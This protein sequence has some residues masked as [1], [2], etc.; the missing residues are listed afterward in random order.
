MLSTAF[1]ISGLLALSAILNTYLPSACKKADFSVI[2]GPF[3][4]PKDVLTDAPAFSFF[5]S[6]LANG[7]LAAA[8]GLA[9]SDLSF[10]LIVSKI[11]ICARFACL[12]QNLKIK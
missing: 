6:F 2:C 3:S 7:F 5:G 1:L 11:V 9:S 10:F 8:F 12:N 4:K